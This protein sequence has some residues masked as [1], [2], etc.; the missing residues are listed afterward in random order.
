MDVLRKINSCS[1]RLFISDN[2]F[3]AR[4]TKAFFSSETFLLEILRQI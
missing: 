1:L 2:D 3:I 4:C